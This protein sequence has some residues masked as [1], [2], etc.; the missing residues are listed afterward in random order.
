MRHRLGTQFVLVLYNEEF[1]RFDIT[2]N[3]FILR[4]I[5]RPSAPCGNNASRP[6]FCHKPDRVTK[7]YRGHFHIN[8]SNRHLSGLQASNW[9]VNSGD[10]SQLWDRLG[11]IRG[12]SLDLVTK[13]IDIGSGATLL[14]TARSRKFHWIYTVQKRELCVG[15]LVLQ[16]R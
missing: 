1:S 3:S 15:S 14:I 7:L 16:R 10:R 2:L 12:P 8:Q 5:L 9:E 11:P 4:C 13:E 6:Q